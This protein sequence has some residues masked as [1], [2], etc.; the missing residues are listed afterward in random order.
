[1]NGASTLQSEVGIM[2]LVE[3]VQKRATPWISKPWK[4]KPKP[5]GYSYWD[6]RTATSRSSDFIFPS[7]L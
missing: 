2:C 5:V 1:M 4:P 7:L 6:K 3:H